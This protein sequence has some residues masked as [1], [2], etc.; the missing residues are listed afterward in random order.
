[1]TKF[2]I[3]NL[4]AHEEHLRN[5]NIIAMAVGRFV[6]NPMQPP[7]LELWAVA[8]QHANGSSRTRARVTKNGEIL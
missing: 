3:I 1:M 6:Y 4:A 2:L 7:E 5:S 8:P